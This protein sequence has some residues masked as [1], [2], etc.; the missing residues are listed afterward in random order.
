[1]I[2][3]QQDAQFS[4]GGS[5]SLRSYLLMIY[6]LPLLIAPVTNLRNTTLIQDALQDLLGIPPALGVITYIPVPEENFA[7]NGTTLRGEITRLERKDE[8]S[9][10]LFKTISRGMSRRLKS[11]SGQSVPLS[12][13]VAS[14]L[15][16]PKSDS[17]KSPDAT[18]ST[19][20]VMGE[21]RGRSLRNRGSL[22]ALVRGRLRGKIQ[23]KD[24]QGGK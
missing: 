8:D 11:N 21:D 12:S 10:S 2:V 17:L 6:A 18:K 5:T 23:R 1:M 4:Y 7:T 19:E 9:P 22:R 20:T 3:L 16:N 24:D 13:G 15:S 14:P